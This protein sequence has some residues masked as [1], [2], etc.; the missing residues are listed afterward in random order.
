MSDSTGAQF[1]M[2]KAYEPGKVEDK[3]YQFWMERD[4]FKPAID[5]QKKPFTIIKIGRAHV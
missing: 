2:A 1:D 3:W 4:Y 5:P